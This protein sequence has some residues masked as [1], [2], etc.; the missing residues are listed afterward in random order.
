MKITKEELRQIIREEL[1]A[2]VD[3][4]LFG[5]KVGRQ[6]SPDKYHYDKKDKPK[7]KANSEYKGDDY[8]VDDINQK[9]AKKFGAKYKKL[10][11]EEEESEEQDS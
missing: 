5:S 4:G 7:K 8:D 10:K 6:L 11:E 9:M 3:E 2:V 1:E